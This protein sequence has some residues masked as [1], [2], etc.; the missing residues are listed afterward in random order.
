MNDTYALLILHR[1]QVQNANAIS[2]PLS[3]GFP[4]P[5][6]FTGFAHALQ[7]RLE[8]DLGAVGIVCHR[9]DPQIDQ[10]DGPWRPGHFRLARQPYIAGW[11]KFKDGA[12]ALIEEGRTHM[13]VSILIEVKEDLDEDDLE[14]LQETLENQL[15]GMRLAGGTLLHAGKRIETLEWSPYAEGQ[16]EAFHKLRYRLLPGFC[17]V[18]RRDLLEQATQ[19]H[20]DSLAAFLDTLAL[21]WEPH[22]DEEAGAVEW[23]TRP[24]PGWIVPIP[25]GY[26]GLS[27]RYPPGAVRNTRDS[28]SPFRFVESLYTLGQWLGPHRLHSL[29][30]MLW[31]TEEP[32]NDGLYLCHNRYSE[33]EMEVQP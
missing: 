16:R 32:S 21:T 2:G 33:T 7:R 30:Q 15:P 11:K 8:I 1:L 28:K 17:L 9:F 31:H 22:A 14:E 29:E 13:E 27:E 26:A 6:A 24:R 19:E 23:R 18:E 10:P 4:S 3:W 20:P 5:T 25:V 12:A